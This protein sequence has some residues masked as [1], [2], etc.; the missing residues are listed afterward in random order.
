MLHANHHS[1]CIQLSN[2]PYIQIQTES[3]AASTAPAPSSETKASACAYMQDFT[4]C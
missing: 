4:A 2:V 1:M 3:Q